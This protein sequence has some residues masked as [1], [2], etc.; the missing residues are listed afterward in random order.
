[1]A[2]D[3]AGC[4]Q[5][6]SSYPQPKF[7]YN[8]NRLRSLSLPPIRVP[9]LRLQSYR[10]LSD[11]PKE[12]DSLT[13][14]PL[15]WNRRRNSNVIGG[16]IV[17]ENDHDDEDLDEEEEDRSLDLLIRFFQNVFKKVSRRARKAV[18]S[19]L[20]TNISSQ[21]VGFSVNGVIILTFMWVLKAFL[22]VICTLGSVVFMSILLIRG[23]WTGISYLQESR[24]Y[25]T[26]ELDDDPPEWRGTQPAI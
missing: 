5:L 19:V 25:R 22:E 13:G 23:V 14:S 10:R 17:D 16:Y 7:F 20:P 18:R 2:L 26:D 1:M 21:L 9:L 15:N 12:G 8:T 24:S 4:S 11:F 3:V 6:I